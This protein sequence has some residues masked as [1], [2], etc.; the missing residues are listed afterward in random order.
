MALPETHGPPRG[1]PASLGPERRLL[2]GVLLGFGRLG[3][4]GLGRRGCRAAGAAAAPPAAAASAV[5]TSTSSA[6]AR[7]IDTTGE[8]LRPCVELGDLDARRQLDVGRGAAIWFML[9]ARQVDRR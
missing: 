1:R 6:R 5:A 4:A 7:W 9:E 8:S 2:L 3:L